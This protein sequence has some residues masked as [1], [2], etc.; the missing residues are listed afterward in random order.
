[1]FALKAFEGTDE[2]ELAKRDSDNYIWYI[3]QLPAIQLGSTSQEVFTNTFNF[4]RD[5]AH[6]EQNLYY[7]SRFDWNQIP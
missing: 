7:S 1:M 6:G 2:L 3:D 4:I 5:N